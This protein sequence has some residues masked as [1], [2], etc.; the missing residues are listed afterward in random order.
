MSSAICIK[1]G[2]CQNRKWT[3]DGLKIK[4]APIWGRL[5]WVS[6]LARLNPID[7]SGPSLTHLHPDLFKR[8]LGPDHNR[9]QEW[10]QPKSE[11]RPIKETSQPISPADE[12]FAD[13]KFSASKGLLHVTREM[14]VTERFPV[15]IC[16]I[17]LSHSHV[18][19]GW[20]WSVSL[21]EDKCSALQL[22][23]FDKDRCCARVEV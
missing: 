4:P 5:K 13:K 11:L 9:R 10:S 6:V 20:T 16:Q 3:E 2:P 15:Y 1:S 21:N 14:L 18:N 19:Y 7:R 17:Q 23:R 22:D 8:S 12:I